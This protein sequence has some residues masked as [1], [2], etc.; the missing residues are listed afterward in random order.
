[1]DREIAKTSELGTT[2]TLAAATFT[3]ALIVLYFAR[4]YTNEFIEKTSE[5]NIKLNTTQLRYFSNIGQ[6]GEEIPAASVYSVLAQEWRGVD[7]IVVYSPSGEVELVGEYD[8]RVWNLVNTAGSPVTIMDASTGQNTSKLMIAEQFACLDL[9]GANSTVRYTNE[10]KGRLKV[11]TEQN[12]STYNY[13][14]HI[15]L[16]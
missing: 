14:M 11:Y 15:V 10:V 8:G 12:M 1:M 6:E 7:E 3:I 5:D 4:F 9:G 16:P 2:L 13:T